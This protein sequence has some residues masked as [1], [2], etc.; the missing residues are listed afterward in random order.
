MRVTMRSLLWVVCGG[1]VG[2]SGA[3]SA[4][5]TTVTIVMTGQLTIVD[6]SNSVTDGSLSVGVP[7]TLTM[8]YDD[9]A[10]DSDSDP[11][12]GTYLMPGATSSYS[13]TVGNYTF[14]AAGVLNIGLL[15]GFFDPSEDTLGWYVDQFSITGTLDPGVS[16]GPVTYSNPAL[17]DYTGAALTSD[18]LTSANWNRSAYASDDQ[19][20]WLFVEV[21]DPST[22]VRDYI[23]LNGT[24]ANIVVSMPEPSL[25]PLLLAGLGAIAA[26][27]RHAR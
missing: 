5:A 19:A 27:R 6:D 7:Y 10:I 18:Q 22:T 3:G 21:L 2:L 16:V 12:S 17:Y 11:T 25:A 15:D 13:I 23:E 24:I 4:S 26:L 20:F 8:V 9:T 14:D 1:L